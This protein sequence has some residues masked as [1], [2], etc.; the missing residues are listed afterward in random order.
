MATNFYE[1]EL[2]RNIS[3]GS[4]FGPGF[5]TSV[6]TMPNKAE[7]RNINWHYPYCS[8][9]LSTGIRKKADFLEFYNFWML[10]KGKAIGFRYYDWL[11]HEGLFML[12]GIGDGSTTNFQLIKNYYNS[13]LNVMQDRK[14]VKPIQDTV[15]LYT[16]DCSDTSKT[17][18][19]YQRNIVN[20]FSSTPPTEISGWAVNV[21]TGI[22][23]MQNAPATG[24]GIVASFEFDVPVRFDTDTMATNYEAYQQL[25]WTDIPVV[26]LRYDNG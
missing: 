17:K 24:V 12:L 1:I 18:A 16:Y 2:P 11:D 13:L 20:E 7:Q 22:V 23:T 14:I 9:N 21:N 6:V 10:C 8:G 3:Y 4:T 25:Q 15:K 19:E 5:S 26:E